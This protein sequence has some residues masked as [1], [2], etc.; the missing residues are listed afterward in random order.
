MCKKKFKE[1]NN[2]KFM[3]MIF[4]FIL[5]LL[6]FLHESAKSAEIKQPYNI[7]IYTFQ[8]GTSTYAFGV[9]Q[10]KFINEQ[11]K[12]LR[13]KAI[14]IPNTII[15]A[16]MLIE[17]PD[18]RT[19]IFGFIDTED[20][21]NGNP[22]FDTYKPPYKNIV[23]VAAF[24]TVFNGLVTLDPNI[25]R[26]ADFSGKKVGLGI[27]PS[28]ARVSLPKD[29]ILASG[30]RNVR[31]VEYDFMGGVRALKD[32]V[33]HG[34]LV[35]GF[36]IDPSTKKFIANPAFSELLS[37]AKVYFVSYEDGSYNNVAKKF[38]RHL[39]ETKLP[40]GS[41]SPMQTKPWN[42]ATDVIG[43]AC[44][45]SMPEDVVYEYVRIM[46]ENVT[47][48]GDF[49]PTGKGLTKKFM[50]RINQPIEYIHPGAIKYYRENGLDKELEKKW[51]E[52]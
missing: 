19:K 6:L 22:P 24:G 50:A 2:G 43:W 13:A 41:I 48:Y 39:A 35:A 25:Q 8:V 9:G 47:K 33:I 37:T 21:R 10:A 27:G 5:P 38:G 18:K 7:E 34:L 45:R 51:I 29:A 36:C 52:D 40:P 32:G 20:P 26:L 17:E 42:V 14:E 11:S 28:M 23:M 4:S 16:K 12:W 3:L 46:A 30:A 1:T 15:T 44:D 31:F 49:H